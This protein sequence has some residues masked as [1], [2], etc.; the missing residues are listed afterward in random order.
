MFNT[1]KFNTLRLIDN[2]IR[3]PPSISKHIGKGKKSIKAGKKISKEILS[4]FMDLTGRGKGWFKTSIYRAI[5]D[6]RERQRQNK[7]NKFMQNFWNFKS[8][9]PNNPHA[10]TIHVK[11]NINSII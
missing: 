1:L 5:Q 6:R 2:I 3:N 9:N 8:K 4:E 11:P 10:L 7:Q